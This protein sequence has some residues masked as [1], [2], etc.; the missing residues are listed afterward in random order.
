ANEYYSRLI[1]EKAPNEDYAL[2]Q[3]GIIKG[4]KGDNEGKLNTLRAVV[5]QFPNSNYAD[6]VAFEIPYLSFT[7]GDY[8]SAISRLQQMIKRSPP[9]SYIPRALKTIGL[10]QY[11]NNDKEA[12]MATIQ[13]V[14]EEYSNTSETA[15]AM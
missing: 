5:E 6:D 7:T 3:Q 1:K 4:L 9:S 11:N 10:A 8:E 14:V 2:F 12:S 13:K 15:Q